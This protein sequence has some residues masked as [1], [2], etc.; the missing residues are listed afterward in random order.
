MRV[1][2]CMLL[3]QLG[4]VVDG[5]VPTSVETNAKCVAYIFKLLN[6]LH[7][8]L[9]GTFHSSGFANYCSRITYGLHG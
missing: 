3:G 8:T 6:L 1:V 7:R 5:V 9:P 4:V 2:Q